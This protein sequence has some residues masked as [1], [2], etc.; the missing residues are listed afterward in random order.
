MKYV[1][2]LKKY[3]IRQI[4]EKV[5]GTVDLKD[6][7]YTKVSSVGGV[8]Y[9]NEKGNE[10]KR[11]CIIEKDGLVIDYNV[12]D[13]EIL[14]RLYEYKIKLKDDISEIEKDEDI[15]KIIKAVSEQLRNQKW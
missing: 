14:N 4:G 3:L 6:N 11:Y 7:L 12:D 5:Q 2:E 1:A 9:S 13:D 8:R 15:V 10:E